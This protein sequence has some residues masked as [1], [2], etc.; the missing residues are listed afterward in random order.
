MMSVVT[1]RL[2]SDAPASALN[3]SGEPIPGARTDNTSSVKFIRVG[4]NNYPYVSAQAVRYWLRNTLETTDEIEWRP[5]P[6]HRE[7]KVAYV[8]GNPLI[9]WDDDLLGYMRAPSKRSKK[10]DESA[11]TPLED[12]QGKPTTVTRAS[13]LRVSTFVSIAPVSI[14]VDYS[15][16]SRQDGDP[17]P[18]EHQFYR[19]TLQG[20]ISLDLNM[21]GKFYYRRR[22]GFQ[23]LDAVRRKMAEEQGL[24]H[25]EDEKA[26]RLNR[27][28]RLQRV[29]SLLYGLGRLQG[30]AKQ[31]IHYTDVSPAVTI[32]AVTTGGNHPFNYL[33]KER[34]GQPQ[35]QEEA[36]AATLEDARDQLLS[37]VFVGWKPGYLPEEQAKAARVSMDGVQIGFSTPRAAFENL[38]GWLAQNQEVWD[39]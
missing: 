19:A 39:A 15:T 16:M 37:P 5:S 22:T 26:Y 31:A 12:E 33:F 4:G 6:V 29:Q 14:T 25:L 18:Y 30:G 11:L 10:E 3:N 9:Y 17:V 35:F 8:D 23:N 36:F 13:P 32:L 27:A 24:E 20:L 38:A 2:L 1:G 7:E 21:A 34:G 28:E